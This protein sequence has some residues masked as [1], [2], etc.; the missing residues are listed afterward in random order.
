MNS[1]YSYCF[2]NSCILDDVEFRLSFLNI[3]SLFKG[4]TEREEEIIKK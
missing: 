1:Y 4:V 3:L 2:D